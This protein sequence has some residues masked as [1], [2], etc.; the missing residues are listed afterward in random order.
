MIRLNSVARHQLA[1][2]MGLA[3]MFGYGHL[4][5]YTGASPISPDAPP[6][7]TLLGYVSRGVNVPTAANYTATGITFAAGPTP[8]T[9][10]DTGDWYLKTVATGRAGWWRLVSVY[11]LLAPGMAAP[12]ID[13]AMDDSFGGFLQDNGLPER[14]LTPGPIE[15]IRAFV[16]SVPSHT[17]A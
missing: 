8:G 6:S 14:F 15:L 13:G 2:E 12:V 4:Q 1:T 17:G 3:P 9:I 10:I 11:E 16:L 5:I 7:G